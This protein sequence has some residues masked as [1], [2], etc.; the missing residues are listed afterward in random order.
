[1]SASST[2]SRSYPFDPAKAQGAD[3]G[4]GR[5]AGPSSTLF[6]APAFD[7]RIVQAIQ[8]MLI[9]V[10]LKVTITSTTSPTG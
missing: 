5:H 2:A 4:S 9:D 10:G 8:Q 7:Q 6:T 3:E 1:M